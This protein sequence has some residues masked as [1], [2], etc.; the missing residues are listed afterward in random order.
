MARRTQAFIKKLIPSCDKWNPILKRL[1][2]ALSNRGVAF[3]TIEPYML[4]RVKD[5]KAVMTP[6]EMQVL[7][8]CLFSTSLLDPRATTMIAEVGVFRG[9]SARILKDF[10]YERVLLLCDTF[11]G[12]PEPCMNVDGH[13]FK[14]GQYK[15]CISDVMDTIDYTREHSD[16]I[17][18]VDGIFPMSW[19][20]WIERE[21]VDVPVSWKRTVE[22]QLHNTKFSFVHLDVDLYESTK[23]SI[24]FFSP[25]MIVGGIIVI[26]DYGCSRGVRQAVDECYLGQGEDKQSVFNM[27]HFNGGTQVALV[28][29]S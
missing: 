4:E 27:L 20:S 9:G 18:F 22:L 5:G 7:A 14:T 24:N 8:D 10:A 28:K 23:A 2:I 15:A 29:V 12:L 13:S 26:H 6:Y 25:R 19:E 17:Y 16:K 1:F 21:L 3:H 11:G